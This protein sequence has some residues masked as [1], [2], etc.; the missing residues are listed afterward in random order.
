MRMICLNLFLNIPNICVL[1]IE[2]EMRENVSSG[3][4]SDSS[5]GQGGGWSERE[6]LVNVNHLVATTLACPTTHHWLP[7]RRRQLIRRPEGDMMAW[8]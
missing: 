3:G 7:C 6:K 1:T 2:D 5:Q 4:E 8:G